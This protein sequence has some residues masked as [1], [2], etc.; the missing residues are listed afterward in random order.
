MLVEGQ[1]GVKDGLVFEQFI[2]YHVGKPFFPVDVVFVLLFPGVE[3]SHQPVQF[4]FPLSDNAFDVFVLN[5]VL[6]DRFVNVVDMSLE[7]G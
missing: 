2:F 7:L 3:V 4:P 6:F 5:S 1:V